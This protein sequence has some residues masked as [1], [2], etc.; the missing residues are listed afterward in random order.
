MNGNGESEMGKK[1][2]NPWVHCRVDSVIVNNW[3]SAN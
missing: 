3:D 2:V 1:Q